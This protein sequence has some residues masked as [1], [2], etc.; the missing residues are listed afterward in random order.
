MLQLVFQFLCYNSYTVNIL[1]MYAVA[2]QAHPPR[3]YLGVTTLFVF[4][5]AIPAFAGFLK[6]LCL[7][8]FDDYC[9][10]TNFQG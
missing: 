3:V 9:K 4:F 6:E 8:L 1:Y 7:V 5:V 10:G 2:F